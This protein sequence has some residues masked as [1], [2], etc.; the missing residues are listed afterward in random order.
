M[1]TKIPS[2]MP[3]NKNSNM[4]KMIEKNGYDIKLIK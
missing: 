2:K 4:N 1:P 3:M